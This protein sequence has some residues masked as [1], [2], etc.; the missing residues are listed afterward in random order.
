MAQKTSDAS[1]SLSLQTCESSSF[2]SSGC[3]VDSIVPFFQPKLIDEIGAVI[4]E[5]KFVAPDAI[6]RVISRR[7][8]AGAV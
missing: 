2:G 5:G 8:T 7:D 4:N 6:V 3:I 1:V